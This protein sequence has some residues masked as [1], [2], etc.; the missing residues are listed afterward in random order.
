V[1]Y[2][3]CYLILYW[4]KMPTIDSGCSF[5]ETPPLE[6]KHKEKLLSYCFGY[7]LSVP[8]LQYAGSLVLCMAIPRGDRTFKRWLLVESD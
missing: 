8:P 4:L 1:D 7:G 6:M 3:I 2:V 5:L